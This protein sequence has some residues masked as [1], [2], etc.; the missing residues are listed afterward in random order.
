MDELERESERESAVARAV[1]E[2]LGGPRD[3][4]KDRV[5]M[6]V[7]AGG[8]TRGVFCLVE[9]HAQGLAQARRVRL[10]GGERAER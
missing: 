10:V 1:A 9:E 7:Q 2:Q 3:A 4:L 6:R 5:A 8:G